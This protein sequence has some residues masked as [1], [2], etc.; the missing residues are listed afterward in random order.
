MRVY[1]RLVYEN[2]ESLI[3][4]V[5]TAYVAHISPE[6]IFC[7]AAHPLHS[8]LLGKVLKDRRK[9]ISFLMNGAD[10]RRIKRQG[11]L[12]WIVMRLLSIQEM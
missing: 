12:P 8:A 10:C 5:F 2:L 6:D 11:I 9:I 4:E 3:R 7:I 1:Q